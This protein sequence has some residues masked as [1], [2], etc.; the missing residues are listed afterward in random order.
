MGDFYNGNKLLTTKDINNLPAEI[1][2]SIG[3]RSGGKTTFFNKWFVKRYI[4]HLEKFILVF[5]YQNELERSFDN[6]SAKILNWFPNT[7]FTSKI[8]NNFL[9]NYY[10]NEKNLRMGNCF[11]FMRQS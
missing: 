4:K 10:I 1:S 6:F 3:N 7:N 9:A 8:D 5:R 11:K 2:I